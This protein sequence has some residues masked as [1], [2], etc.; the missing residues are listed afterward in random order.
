M[1]PD[2]HIPWYHDCNIRRETTLTV[3]AVVLVC[4][5]THGVAKGV[6]TQPGDDAGGGDGDHFRHLGACLRP[7]GLRIVLSVSDSNWLRGRLAMLADK[8]NI[9]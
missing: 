2:M 7:D 4:P 3:Y 6:N 1:S 8:A 9:G 5:E